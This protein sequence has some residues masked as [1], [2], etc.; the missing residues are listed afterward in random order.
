M[1]ACL[2]YAGQSMHC[3]QQKES[4]MKR[5][6]WAFAFFG[7]LFLTQGTSVAERPNVLLVLADDMT[8]H[9]SGAYG[10]DMVRTPN[11]DRLAREGMLF[12]RMFTSTA[13]CSPTRNGKSP[14]S[15]SSGDEGGLSLLN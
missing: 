15:D 4:G 5:L 8:Y 7:V 1:T 9:D 10:S 2:C 14:G 11:I 13:M 6:L 3:W 12:Q